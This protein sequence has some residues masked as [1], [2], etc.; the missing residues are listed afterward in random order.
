[1]VE[2]KKTLLSVVV[3]IAC[4]ACGNNTSTPVASTPVA[5]ASTSAGKAVDGYVNGASVLCDSNS[6]GIADPGEAVVMTSGNGDFQFPTAC[7]FPI[8]VTG[9]TNSDTHLPFKGRLQ[10]LPGSLVVTPLTSLM[11]NGL[12]AVQIATLLGLPAGTDVSKVDPMTSTVLQTKGLAVQQLIQQIADTIASLGGDSSPATTQAIYSKVAQSVASSATPLF[13][14]TTNAVTSSVVNA[15]TQKSVVAVQASTDASF[16]VF[17]SATSAISKIGANN[18]AVLISGAV[19]A[20][21]TSLS[22]ATAATLTTVAASL[23]ASSVIASTASQL[24]AALLSSST[25]TSANL[26]TL[27]T[28]VATLGSSSTSIADAIKNVVSAASNLNVSIDATKILT[29]TNSFSIVNDSIIVN[30]T[31]LGLAAFEST[32]GVSVARNS[33]SID[34]VSLGVNLNGTPIPVNASGVKSSTVSVALAMSDT[35]TGVRALQ[36]M[37]DK[38]TLSVDNNNML[39][40]TVPVGAKLYAYGKTANGSSANVT[41]NDITTDQFVV[42]SNNQLTFNAGKV[43][44]RILNNI[45]AQPAGAIQT[46]FNGLT[47]VTGTFK[48]QMAVSNFNIVSANPLLVTGLAIAVTGSGQTTLYGLG[49]SGTVTVTQ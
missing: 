13:D 8:V 45:N 33:V 5:V 24:G 25:I 11:A 21:A 3:A 6:N 34:T 17:S 29:P 42:S 48:M 37:L 39:I 31:T 10:A 49:L 14:P 32:A 35:G 16:A 28:A 44:A 20:Q 38:V 4:T 43:L 40:V 27:G 30:G 36:I 1:M 22:L 47:N 2:M 23:Q 46:V 15:I 18:V 9:G 41:I 19:A 12:T 7:A 26:T